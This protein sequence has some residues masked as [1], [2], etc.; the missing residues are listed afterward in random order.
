MVNEDKFPSSNKTIDTNFIRYKA[1]IAKAFVKDF[2][3]FYR[4]LIVLFFCFKPE[5]FYYTCKKYE[6]RNRF[7]QGNLRAKK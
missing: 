7:I 5:Y 1:G 2:E 3:I 6:G 4:I